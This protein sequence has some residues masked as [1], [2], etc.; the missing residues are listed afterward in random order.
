M[1]ILFW[2]SGTS[3]LEGCDGLGMRDKVWLGEC[4]LKGFVLRKRRGES[5]RGES[6]IISGSTVQLGLSPP[7]PTKMEARSYISNYC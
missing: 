1:K 3:S 6:C 5:W 2:K 4:G 7:L